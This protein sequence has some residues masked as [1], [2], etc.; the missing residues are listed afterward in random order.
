MLRKILFITHDY[1]RLLN[2]D[3]QRVEYHDKRG[4]LLAS[5][6]GSEFS[7]G[8]LFRD[9]GTTIVKAPAG[10][11]GSVTQAKIGTMPNDSAGLWVQVMR[12]TPELSNAIGV[13]DA[14]V[15]AVELKQGKQ[16]FVLRSV[17]GE[18]IVPGD[19]GG[20]IYYNGQLVGNMWSTIREEVTTTKSGFFGS[21]MEVE[22]SRDQSRGAIFTPELQSLLPL[23]L[24]NGVA[25]SVE[26]GGVS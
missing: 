2:D 24:T 17:K 21:T 19:S 23:L 7:A 25:P 20:G 11:A 1:W 3:L 6:S 9:G 12:K 26:M 13:M 4:N 15:E 14:V 10:L 22:S 5:I 16:V 18:S 8:I